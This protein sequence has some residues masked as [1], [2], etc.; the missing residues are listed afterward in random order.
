MVFSYTFHRFIIHDSWVFL[1]IYQVAVAKFISRFPKFLG[2][3]LVCIIK[4]EEFRE[5]V[6]FGNKIKEV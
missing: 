4:F 5:F 2:C 1:N 6:I 3:F